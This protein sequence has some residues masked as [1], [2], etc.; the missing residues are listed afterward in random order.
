MRCSTSD[1]VTPDGAQFARVQAHAAGQPREARLDLLGENAF[2]FVRR[3]GQQH[4][5]ASIGF[6]PQTGRGAARILQHAGAF[7]NHGLARVHFRPWCVPAGGSA[8]RWRA[9]RPGCRYELAA[10]QF[11]DRLARQVVLVGP[12]PPVA[13]TSSARAERLPEGIAKLIVFVADHGLALDGDA[14]LVQALGEEQGVCIQAIGREQF[15]P[16]GDDFRF[17]QR[18]QRQALDVPVEAEERARCW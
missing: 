2:Q 3:T 18:E 9:G 14:Q 8:L 15:R 1:S 10:Q 16:D 6:D 11:G 17:H 5:D 12:S 13:T 7:G 4:D